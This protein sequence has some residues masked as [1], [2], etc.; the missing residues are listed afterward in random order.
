MD[1]LYLLGLGALL[2]LL[3]GF[4]HQRLAAGKIAKRISGKTPLLPKALHVAI[5]AT[6]LYELVLVV[7]HASLIT[8]A[9]GVMLLA[10]VT[11]TKSGTEGQPQIKN[12][13]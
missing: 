2:M 6:Q 13:N 1:P 7:E 11:A 8:L 4:R 12:T 5:I 9:A 10:I 3:F